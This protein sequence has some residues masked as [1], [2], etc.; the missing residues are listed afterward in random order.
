MGYLKRF[1]DLVGGMAAFFATV[2]LF[3]KYMESD[4]TKVSEGKSKLEWF[5]SSDNTKEYRQYLVLIALIVLTIAVGIILKNRPSVSLVVSVLPM[6]QAMAML[7]RG[8]FYEFS[9]FYVAV[10]MLLFGGHLYEAF[11]TDKETGSRQA[12]IA[13]RV[14]GALG[15]VLAAASVLASKTATKFSDP[16]IDDA[17]SEANSKVMSDLK[18]FGLLLSSAAPEKEVSVLISIAVAFAACVII[19]LLLKRIYFIDAIL[20][21]VPFILS[22]SALHEENL[23]TAPMLV[24]VPGVAYFVC[25]L[26]LVFR[27]N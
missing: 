4:P 27:K 16:M 22:V 21:L 10:S 6:C 11:A 9:H 15:V 25:C 13:T 24:I 17:L 19:G 5:F 7:Y 8:Q 12:V 23:A 2:F 14:I 18:P 20:A 1:S 26:A 3:G